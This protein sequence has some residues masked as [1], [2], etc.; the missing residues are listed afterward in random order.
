MAM[1]YLI[2]VDWAALFTPKFSVLEMV[3]RG[4]AVYL[5]LCLLI[6]FVLKRQA[7]KVGLGDLLVVMLVTGICRNPLVAD[8]YSITDGLG[9]VA[10]VLSCNY[11]L[12]AAS[13]HC[14][15]LTRLLDARP[16]QLIREG[17]VLPDNLRGEMMTE[18]Q[19]RCKLRARGVKDPRQVAEAWMEGNGEVSVIKT[20]DRFVPALSFRDDSVHEKVEQ[21]LEAVRMLEQALYSNQQLKPAQQT[22]SP[23][24]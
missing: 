5:G 21:L 23:P 15:F 7:G 13:Y 2:D 9:V 16:V 18:S 24:H 8:A 19:L 3:V 10:V 12:D 6:R 11:L 20:S 22:Q 4:V 17:A 14:R 1:S